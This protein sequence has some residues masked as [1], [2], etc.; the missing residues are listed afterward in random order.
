[1]SLKRRRKKEEEGGEEEGIRC[2][3]E[4]EEY[5]GCLDWARILD[6]WRWE[7]AKATFHIFYF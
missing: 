5:R 2:E 1:M 7:K 6:I 4:R 3:S